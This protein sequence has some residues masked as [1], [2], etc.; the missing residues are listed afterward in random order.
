MGRLRQ[1]LAEMFHE[2][3]EY[4]ELLYRM[5]V[6]DLLVRYKQAVMG[7]GWAVFMPL[8]SSGL[9]SDSP[10]GARRDGRAVSGVAYRA[11]CSGTSLPLVRFATSR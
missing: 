4:R 6:R 2:Q 10:G 3:V 9:H 5:T 1:D 8:V 7:F 11:C